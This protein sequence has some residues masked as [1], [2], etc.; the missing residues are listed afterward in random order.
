[1][2]AGWRL[3]GVLGNG[4]KS[5]RFCCVFWCTCV[6]HRCRELVSG[7]LHRCDYLSTMTAQ[8]NPSYPA[9]C[10][11]DTSRWSTR[12]RR[13]HQEFNSDTNASDE[14]CVKAKKKKEE[15]TR[16]YATNQKS[17]AKCQTIKK[18]MKNKKMESPSNGSFPT[19][20]RPPRPKIEFS[21][22][23]IAIFTSRTSRRFCQ[24]WRLLGRQNNEEKEKEN[25]E[26]KGQTKEKKNIGN[27][28]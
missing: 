4:P 3:S 18:K 13:K 27:K 2:V 21:Q 28:F 19:F 11:Q 5:S 10:R 25:E 1:M 15:E 23:K 7:T 20:T 26:K 16:F 14:I 17:E 6:R 12:Q 24:C 9:L 22:R 8:P